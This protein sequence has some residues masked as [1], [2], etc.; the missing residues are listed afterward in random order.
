MDDS[1]STFIIFHN[2]S[3]ELLEGEQFWNATSFA[4]KDAQ[5]PSSK[6]KGLTPWFLDLR[7]VNGLHL[8]SPAV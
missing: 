7:C 5:K 8:L 6:A 3:D 1:F 4:I 2:I